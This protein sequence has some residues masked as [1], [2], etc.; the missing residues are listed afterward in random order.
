MERL[1]LN[2]KKD[3]QGHDTSKIL[4]TRRIEKAIIAS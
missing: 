3:R 4:S 2:D 1:S